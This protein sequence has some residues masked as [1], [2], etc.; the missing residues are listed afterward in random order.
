MIVLRVTAVIAH[1]QIEQPWPRGDLARASILHTLELSPG[2]HLVLVRYSKSHKYDHEWVYNAADID[3]S[4]VVWARDMDEQRNLELLRY[5][6]GR[7]VWLVEPD[8]FP[9]RLSPYPQIL[10]Q[11]TAQFQLE[12]RILANST[13]K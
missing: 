11:A 4:K 8:E 5:F 10:N 1:I 2:Q 9:P 7:R 3:R 6:Q 12:A 13:S